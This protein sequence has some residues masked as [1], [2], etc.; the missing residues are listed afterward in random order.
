M[1]F[2][3][4]YRI[5][6]NLILFF[7][8]YKL[9][10]LFNIC[11]KLILRYRIHQ[12][13]PSFSIFCI[14]LGYIE[15]LKKFILNFFS[16]SKPFIIK[17]YIIYLFT[18]KIYLGFYK[19]NELFF[20]KKDVSLKKLLPFLTG[21]YKN[22]D[23][24]DFLNL[25]C[26]DKETTFIKLITDNIIIS[27]D[28]IFYRKINLCFDNIIHSEKFKKI[29]PY[30]QSQILVYFLRVCYI[31]GDMLFLKKILKKISNKNFS[32][33]YYSIL[34]K[35]RDDYFFRSDF[36]RAT[37][38][39]RI[40]NKKHSKSNHELIV[41]QPDIVHF[42][43][44]IPYICHYA[45][46]NPKKIIYFLVDER[47]FLLLSNIKIKNLNFIKFKVNDNKLIKL[48]RELADKKSFYFLKK[49]NFKIIPYHNYRFNK[50]I[51]KSY[52][53]G[54][55][56]TNDLNAQEKNLFYINDNKIN[57]GISLGSTLKRD[58]RSIYDI[59]PKDIQ[60]LDSKKYNLIS[61]APGLKTSDVQKY[62]S[63]KI[64]KFDLFN[65]FVNLT[66][67]IS[68]CDYVICNHNNIMD[69]AGAVGTKTFVI[70]NTHQMKCWSIKGNQYKI[71]SKVNFI[72]TKKEIL[73]LKK[74]L[75]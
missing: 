51:N 23:L 61:L 49:Y 31:F 72:Y 75:I 34:S 69:I 70:S 46:R 30:K 8:L 2:K 36:A 62:F 4:V 74:L 35:Y 7:N 43:F 39:N 24:I 10:F 47:L 12:L 60:F 50:Q 53:N 21:N 15:F 64:P 65:D 1:R 42:F 57:I 19:S 11:A 20:M 38:L 26:F 54:W 28:V 55:I 59:N 37:T 3:L 27:V 13:L 56:K 22:R 18:L 29:H 5:L 33:L 73:G 9:N 25:I 48:Y 67:L 6:L 58:S 44:K 32:Y 16:L 41:P 68:H 14:K 45:K 63:I 40:L 17:K 71:F 52:K 66:K